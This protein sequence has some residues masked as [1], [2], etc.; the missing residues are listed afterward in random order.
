ML[1]QHRPPFARRE[2]LQRPAEDVGLMSADMTELAEIFRAPLPHKSH[3]PQRRSNWQI[4]VPIVAK[5]SK[6]N[7]R[8]FRRS[9]PQSM[10]HW[11]RAKRLDPEELFIVSE[12]SYAYAPAQTVGSLQGC[13]WYHSMDL[14]VFGMVSGHWDLRGRFDDYVGGVPL[15][16]R[17]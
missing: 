7:I 6:P 2:Q 14:P 8:V 16:A 17:C 10:P 15:G 4:I 5:P 12:R 3:R 13:W 1:I 11:M 9:M